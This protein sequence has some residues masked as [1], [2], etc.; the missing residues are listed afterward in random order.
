MT[1]DVML[2]GVERFARAGIRHKGM[3]RLFAIILFTATAVACSGSANT[4]T[5]PSPAPA[6]SP[7][8]IP[9]PTPTP[10]PTPAPT[11]APGPRTDPDYVEA[12]FLG[13][14]PLI[15]RD[16]LVACPFHGYFAGFQA[17]SLITITI[18]TTVSND[19]GNVIR[20]TAAQVEDA[21]R[22]AIRVTV[23]STSETTPT[24]VTNE[25]TSTTHAAPSSQGCVRDVGCI[26]HGFSSPGVF[27]DGRAVQPTSIPAAGYAHDVIGHGVL[28]MCHVDGQLIGGARNSLMSGGPGVFSGDL[29]L[30]LTERDIRAIQAVYATGVRPG[31]RRAD[32]V[33]ANL[34]NP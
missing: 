15:P 28:G 8:P 34:I 20:Q 4:P 30:Q 32:F 11:P 16:G 9:T 29:P 31:A 3:S 2:A 25:V 13:S 5:A 7:S 12:L 27:R 33:A 21:S 26:I 22:G 17:P 6:P 23:R 19:R 24:P 14:G 10:S 1:H 18:S